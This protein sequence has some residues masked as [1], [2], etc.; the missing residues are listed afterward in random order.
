[1]TERRIDAHSYGIIGNLYRFALPCGCDVGVAK[2][3]GS[4]VCKCG[5]RYRL[6]TLGENETE[7]KQ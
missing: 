2:N 3:E 7:G 4:F 1:M 5:I 6:A